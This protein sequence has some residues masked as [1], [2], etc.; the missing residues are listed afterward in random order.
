[1]EKRMI[2]AE[3]AR[4]SSE[5]EAAKVWRREAAA[6]M[7]GAGVIAAAKAAAWDVS[8]AHVKDLKL[9]SGAALLP[10]RVNRNTPKRLQHPARPRQP[11]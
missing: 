2:N 11:S 4:C 3:K 9:S 7:A 8:E 6:A 10:S 5:L 1:M